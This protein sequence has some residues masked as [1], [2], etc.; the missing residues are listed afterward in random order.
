MGP[1]RP[2]SWLNRLCGDPSVTHILLTHGMRV[3]GGW[4]GG[5]GTVPP[6][7]RASGRGEPEGSQRAH[8]Q[9]CDLKE[10]LGPGAPQPFSP[11][12]EPLGRPPQWL[13]TGPV[14]GSRLGRPRRS[15]QALWSGP[16]VLVLHRE[17]ELSLPD[18]LSCPR[19]DRGGGD[20]ILRRVHQSQPLVFESSGDTSSHPFP[21]L[22][23]GLTSPGQQ[24]G[25]AGLLQ[26]VGASAPQPA[27]AGHP[28][29]AWC[30]GS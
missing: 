27:R 9:L 22:C 12:A 21:P 19:P 1:W 7:R 17:A 16:G 3:V 30:A 4:V 8:P 11:E 25:P 23:K 18:C 5:G 10:Q 13:V 26:G 29:Q 14:G 28:R 20:Q 24:A 6:Q 15:A 2:H